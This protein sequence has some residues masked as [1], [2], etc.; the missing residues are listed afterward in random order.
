MDTTARTDRYDSVDNTEAQDSTDAT[1]RK[2]PT[3]ATERAEPTDPN[4]PKDPIDPTERIDPLE[5]ML[6]RESVEFID[7]RERRS[8][9]AMDTSLTGHGRAC[10]YL[11]MTALPDASTTYQR[12]PA[13]VRA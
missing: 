8:D 2:L 3:E 13:L 1:P 12:P 4:E 7:H 9:G 10:R 5:L 6:S 11:V